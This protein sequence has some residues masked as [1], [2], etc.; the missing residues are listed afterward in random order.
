MHSSWV[1][2][3]AGAISKD[4]HL[5]WVISIYIDIKHKELNNAPFAEFQSNY[6]FYYKD[7]DP[8]ISYVGDTLG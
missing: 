2:F 1:H 5:N 8:L 6:S 7:L 3:Q 4:N